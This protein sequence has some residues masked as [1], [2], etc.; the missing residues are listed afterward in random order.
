MSQSVRQ[1]N[2]FAAEDWKKIY[3][4]FLNVNFVSYDFNTIRESLINY[5]RINYAED[6]ND[7]IESSEFIAIIDLLA[8]LGQ[9]LAFRVDLNVRENFIDTAE[10]RESLLKLA[11]LLGYKPR[12]NLPAKGFLKI[13]AVQTDD[14]IFDSNNNLLSGLRVNWNDV[15][16]PDWYEQFVLILNESF[17]KS[18]PFGNPI[19]SGKDIDGTRI[20]TY[21]IDSSTINTPGVYNFNATIDGISLDFEIVPVT[22]SQNFGYEE[23]PPNPYGNFRLIYKNDGK[24]NQ[25]K[26]TGFFVFF[27]Q[28]NLRYEDFN[29]STPIENRIVDINV[30]NI[31]E[32]DVWV[33]TIN[34][35]GSVITQWKKVPV[36]LNT[37]IVYNNIPR[38]ERNIFSVETR[39]RDQIS[40]RFS[41]GRFGNVP[42]GLTRI[43]YRTSFGQ[44]L[45]IK[46]V[47]IQNIPIDIIYVNRNGVRK[48]LTLFL[49]LQESITN[50]TPSETDEEIRTRAPQVFYSQ[51]RM[52]TGEDYNVYP[53]LLFSSPV[54]IKAI[55]RTY[56]GHSRYIDINDPTGNYQNTNVLGDDGIIYKEF[57]NRVYAVEISNINVV[58]E[59][60]QSILLKEISREEFRNFII[61]VYRNDLKNCPIGSSFLQVPP[62][63]GPGN[64]GIIWDRITGTN[65]SSTG[66]FVSKLSPIP[67]PNSV[68]AL[69]VGLITPAQTCLDIIRPGSLLK[70]KNSGWASVVS[71]VLDGKGPIPGTLGEG[72]TP[73]NEGMIKLNKSVQEG[74]ELEEVLPNFNKNFSVTEIENIKNKILLNQTFGL[75]FDPGENSW[76]TIDPPQM[77]PFSGFIIDENFSFC[78]DQR[79][80]MILFE[81][82]SFSPFEWKI[83]FRSLNYV[84]E[85]KKD[86]RFFFVNKYNVI[87]RETGRKRYDTIKVFGTNFSNRVLDSEKWQQGKS[88]SKG[89]IVQYGDNFYEALVSG[90]SVSAFNP[91]EWFSVCPSLG[92]DIDLKIYDNYVYNDGYIEPRRV[93]VSFTNDFSGDSVDDPSIFDKLIGKELLFWKVYK[94]QNGYIGYEPIEI[95]KIFIENTYVSAISNANQYYLNPATRTEWKHNE[96]FYVYGIQDSV[97]KY[98]LFDK[99]NVYT[100][101]DNNIP[102]NLNPGDVKIPSDQIELNSALFKSNVGRKNLRFL[103]KHYAPNDHRI[104]PSV[105]NIIDIFVLDSE[106]DQ[107][108]RKYVRDNNNNMEKPEPPSSS[109]L[110]LRYQNL[111]E[112]K[113]I[114]DEIIWHPVKYKLIFGSKAD[115]KFRAKFR[116]VKNP[117][118]TLS[119]GEIRSKI[120]ELFDIYFD[121]K[122]WDF[123]ETFYFS[124]LAAFIHQ[125]LA[126]QISSFVIVPLSDNSKFGDLFEIR[127]EP[128][129][130]FLHCVKVSDIEIVDSNFFLLDLKR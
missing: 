33:Q 129:E 23:L 77:P 42:I 47:D 90:T 62:P 115:E 89:E 61:D 56:S 109:L 37:N 17:L 120:V 102:E 128:D 73:T 55:N 52:V 117:N 87:D 70:F 126:L 79:K 51:N 41:D 66:R 26:N 34:D 39:E 78:D 3:R 84:W 11:Y 1:N 130:I 13:V 14:E 54:K 91:S 27:K 68:Q 4:S 35:D 20:Q 36:T 106:Y 118:A 104:D 60:V 57:V 72:F 113:M 98:F 18:N 110:S 119:D 2:L 86:V 45:T 74:D 58:G 53:S 94:D 125:N 88:Y 99:N 103:W 16:N 82:S 64:N 44:R 101:Y 6:F 50:S 127:S 95:E 71:V 108:M 32:T 116:V 46:P 43:Y 8:W 65:R 93:Y 122:N 123:G 28:G 10:R 97:E 85:S 121:P 100:V 38:R 30:D 111:E 124:E 92:E 107:E 29:F 75:Y 12:R 96:I 24:G 81:K 59:I 25:S 76:I 112:V 5:I 48:K 7:F 15:N 83:Y 80:W 67:V 63:I 22:W 9:S 105:S 31:N 69:S 21:E 114:S 49:G 19:Q 40:V